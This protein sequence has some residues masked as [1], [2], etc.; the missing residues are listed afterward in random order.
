LPTFFGMVG[1]GAGFALSVLDPE[2]ARGW[3]RA[4]FVDSAVVGGGLFSVVLAAGTLSLGQ[5]VGYGLIFLS[6]AAITA[7]AVALSRYWAP[8][9]ETV[10]LADTLGIWGAVV[11][12]AASAILP[13]NQ[14]NQAT[15]MLGGAAAGLAT[16]ALMGL[17]A[18]GMTGWR[19]LL[20]N[21][22][23]LMGALVLGFG[24]SIY[25]T[26]A[27]S[28]QRPYDPAVPAA[29][30]AAGIAGGFLVG[31]AFSESL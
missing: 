6:D 27:A 13:G 8:R 22:G 23:A 20:A 24:L 2:P 18:Q 7:S 11:G 16:G 17:S 1:A 30:I 29:G 28:A 26:A 5:Q 14:F 3:G 21:A 4:A 9:P 10:L 25:E 15:F 12:A 31:F 19:V